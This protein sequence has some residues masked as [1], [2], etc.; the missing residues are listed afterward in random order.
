MRTMPGRRA[1][2]S[3][4]GGGRRPNTRHAGSPRQTVIF[5]EETYRLIK[6]RAAAREWSF[7]HTVVSLCRRALALDS[8]KD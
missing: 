6:A 3:A 7:S 2:R 5:D 4:G 1:P 8:G